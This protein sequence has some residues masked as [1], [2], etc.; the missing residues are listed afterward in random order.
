MHL[1]KLFSNTQ[2]FSS[3]RHQYTKIICR[4]YCCVHLMFGTIHWLFYR[5][6]PVQH[7]NKWN[8]LRERE[9]EREKKKKHVTRNQTDQYILV[10]SYDRVLFAKHTHTQHLINSLH[11]FCY[12]YTIHNKKNYKSIKSRFLINFIRRDLEHTKRYYPNRCKIV[13]RPYGMST[14]LKSVTA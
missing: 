11:R 2:H 1:V 6:L 12:M 14:M 8:C 10:C 5:L 7:A 3:F 9:R 13:S 4:K